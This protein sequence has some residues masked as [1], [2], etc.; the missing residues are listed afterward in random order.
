[1]RVL[2]FALSLSPFVHAQSTVSDTPVKGADITKII[3]RLKLANGKPKGE[4]ETTAEFNARAAMV[5]QDLSK[6]MVFPLVLGGDQS[7]T[8]NA[9]RRKMYVY[10]SLGLHYPDTKHVTMP[11]HRVITTLAP[12]RA[13]NAF[14]VAK[15]ISKGA[16]KEQ[17]I[18]M[19]PV[20]LV[21]VSFDIEPAAAQ[22][23]KPFL[24]L[25]V[26]GVITSAA[27]QIFNERHTPTMTEPADTTVDGEYVQVNV[28]HLLVMDVRDGSYVATI[29]L[30]A[31]ASWM[32]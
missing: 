18:A 28:S 17:G 32:N 23:V 14:G 30:S 29:P 26:S 25:G 5:P 21:G 9:D 20:E 16:M 22:R 10:I 1:M 6:P 8:Y 27:I 4:F 19:Q 15:T 11:M 3:A 24:C 13:S 12:Y 7:I 31:K 2:W